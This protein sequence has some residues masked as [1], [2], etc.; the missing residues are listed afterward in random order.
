[1]CIASYGW[2]PP[3]RGENQGKAEV[4]SVHSPH[5]QC[6]TITSSF[7]SP[8]CNS[9]VTQ[10][11]SKPFKGAHFRGASILPVWGCGHDNPCLLMP[12]PWG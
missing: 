3:L 12:A 1:M 4:M 7:P 11:A 2:L 6:A 5:L 10:M 8:V 9:P